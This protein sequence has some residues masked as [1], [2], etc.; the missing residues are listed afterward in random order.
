MQPV[1]FLYNP[2][3]GETVITEWLDTIISIYQR[4]GCTIVPYRLGFRAGEP[5]LI[6]DLLGH[7]YRH[8]LVAGGDGTVNYVVGIMKHHGIDLPVAVLPTGTANDFAG[9]LGVPGDI[10]RA[11]RAIPRRRG[12]ACRPG[13][14]GRRAVRQRLQ[15]RPFS[16]M[17]RKKTPTVL[18]NNFG[19]LAY[20]FGGLGELPNF[21]KMHITIRSEEVDY[22]GTSLIFFVFNGR[23]AGKMRF[24]YSAE[25]D[26]GLLDVI[27]V[28]GDGPI[29][30]LRALFHFIRQ[31]AGLRRLDPGDYPEGVLHFKSRD[32]VVDSP[33][34]RNEVTDID[35]QPGPRFPVR[36]TCEAG[37]LRVIRPAHHRKD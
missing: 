18:K 20:Y 28:K 3:A 22:D 14:R 27:V 31:N 24:A 29:G 7:G 8:V 4:R 33:M 37:A 16:P 21:R 2:T 12:S 30:T 10:S 26:D 34:R 1:C 25:I 11:C 32:F 23:T 17:C 15:L 6:A 19:K 9:M 5:E 13:C 36:I 35:G